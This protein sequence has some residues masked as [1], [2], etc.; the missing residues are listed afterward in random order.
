MQEEHTAKA[1]TAGGQPVSLTALLASREQRVAYQRQLLADNPQAILL[2]IKLNIP[3]PVKNSP[4]IQHIFQAGWLALWEQ[5]ADLNCVTAQQE[6]TLITG[7]AAYILVQG[8]SLREMKSLAMSFERDFFF[9][10]LFDVDVLGASS[11]QALSRQ[12]LGFAPRPCL[13]CDQPAKYCAKSGRHDLATILAALDERYQAYFVRE[14][15][16]PHWSSA[17]VARMGVA[18]CLYEATATIKPGLVDPF[19]VG[20]HRDMTAFTF[21]DSALVLQPYFEKMLVQGRRFQGDDVTALLAAIRPIGREAETVMFAHTTGANTHKGILFTMGIFLA[22]YGYA[23]QAGATTLAQVQTVIRAM[24]RHLVAQELAARTTAQA[25]AGQKQYARFQLT[26][27]RGE[28]ERGLQPLA[29]V[30]LPV[31]RE[32]SGT[33]NERLLDSLLALAGAIDDSTLIKRA[34][35]PAAVSTVKAAVAKYFALGGAQTSA[36]FRYL[37]ALDQDFIAKN[38]TLGGAADY[39]ILTILVGKMTGLLP[40]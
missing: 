13:V 24:A 6:R 22:A 1:V 2:A 4:K 31:L 16:L 19:S 35:D 5:L 21:M 12:D 14:P 10:R 37:T 9:G 26:G 11:D 34:G 40:D 32:G 27:V 7:P 23:S 29:T 8:Q 36:G 38:W 17:Q 15:V 25:T 30:G 20:A 18:A 3:G 39:L 33:V 28:V